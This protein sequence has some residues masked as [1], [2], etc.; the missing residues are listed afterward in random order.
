MRKIRTDY[1]ILFGIILTGTILRLFGIWEMPFT[2]DEFSAI[3]RC[4]FSSFKALIEKGVVIPDTHP[5]GVQ[6][7]LY[8]WIK[9]FGI[10]E[11]WVRI[12]FILFG[13]GAVYFA[14]K[15]ASRWFNSTSGLI[16]AAFLACLQYTI[17]YSQ[18][19][20]PYAA[21]MFFTLLMVHFWNQIVFNKEKIHY[22]DFAGFI[23]SGAACA[24]IHHFALFFAAMV[25]V[26][27]LFIIQ[28]KK[29]VYYIIA[30]VLIFVLYIPH[31][32]IFF[33]QLS[34]GGN[35]WVG[36]P[37]I[38]FIW[39][40]FIF[41]L[42]HSVLMYV[43]FLSLTGFGI[44]WLIK[45]KSRPGRKFLILSFTWFLLPFITAFVY[46]RLVAPVLQYSVLIFSFPFLL[47]G[48][49]S[50]IDIQ[51]RVKKI[52]ICIIICAIS[53]FTLI[54]NRNY[55]HIM[56]NSI[57]EKSVSQSYEIAESLPDNN[58]LILTNVFEKSVI[59]YIDRYQI[60]NDFNYLSLEHFRDISQII[61]FLKNCKKD[62]IIL[63]AT[64]LTPPE[65]Y[66]VIKHYYPYTHR[67]Y[68][69]FSG[70]IYHFSRFPGD[71]IIKDYYYESVNDFEHPQPN[72]TKGNKDCYTERY[73]YSG[74]YAY[75]MDA[76]TEWGPTY[77]IPLD[78]IMQHENDFID[79]TVFFK[80]ID[81][82]KVPNLISSLESDGENI[83]WRGKSFKQYVIN[84]TGWNKAYLSLKL[85][86]TYLRYKNI[87][88]KT[89]I[90]N[91]H[92]GSFIIDRFSVRSR[93][94]N[95]IIYSWFEKIEKRQ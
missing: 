41:I 24:Y 39:E 62:N 93:V 61:R 60:K 71:S 6:V 26:S 35:D 11:F 77:S 49:F 92:K 90:W 3:H 7:F 47:F 79:I 51:N 83:D 89:Y 4:D 52:T 86:D 72:W 70:N 76:H 10:S 54:Y 44:F 66:T 95:P 68:N 2:H 50:L 20:R 48:L 31:L 94:G 1:Y 38:D 32:G 63:A 78:S 59:F 40:Y 43:L 36:K 81:T 8:Y 69:Y 22:T 91:K 55:Y 37:R 9:I 29:I 14:Y 23:V 53:I 17:M 75:R 16:S 19:A 34:K 87:E 42:H 33:A 82:S 80:M 85:S 46:S 27:G 13:L 30:C 64:A 15:I 18:F 84:D 5:A 45:N 58:Y 12:P 28:R 65:V 21:G 74:K 25:G 73:A 88:L 56:H 67:F 57:I